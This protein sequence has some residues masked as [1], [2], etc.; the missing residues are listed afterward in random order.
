[1]PTCCCVL[2]AREGGTGREIRN[3]GWQKQSLRPRSCRLPGSAS[4]T[5]PATA[6]A[7]RGLRKGLGGGDRRCECVMKILVGRDTTTAVDG[8]WMGILASANPWSLGRGLIYHETHD[9]CGG[10][11]GRGNPRTP[12]RWGW[13][14]ARVGAS[15][16][17][18]RRG[19][20]RRRREQRS[21]ARP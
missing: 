1:M 7:A 3:R 19:G 15:P 14:V 13:T 10:R 20:G 21:P 2:L 12:P 17:R 16:T 18:A 9:G 5:K 6:A 4:Y 11:S 8:R